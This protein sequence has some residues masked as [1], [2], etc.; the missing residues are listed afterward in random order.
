MLN[1]NMLNASTNFYVGLSIVAVLI[2]VL[3]IIVAIVPIGLWFKALF[4]GCYISAT[5]LTGLR[6]RKV[7][8]SLIVNCYIN[9]KKA[10][11]EISLQDL[12]THLVVGGNIKKITEALITAKTAKVN[13]SVETAKALDLANKDVVNI[14]KLCVTPSVIVTNPISAVAKDGIELIVKARVTIVC[15]INKVLGGANEDTIIARINEVV[16]SVVGNAKTHTNILENPNVISKT[17]LDKKIDSATAFNILSADVEEINI[18][19]NIGAKLQAERAEAD[20]QIAQAK[21]EERRSLA[22][23][24]EQEMRART[25]EKQAQLL[26]AEAEVPKAISTAFRSGKIGVMDFYKMKNVLSDSNKEK[27]KK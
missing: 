9:A 1:N 11:V 18:G 23:A 16:V 22:I 20:M 19:K 15:D 10:G 7:N 13:L 2:I 14:V 27:L 3:A 4:S 5:K 21:A 6:L 17:I 25:Q 8:A 24:A 26:D 12:E